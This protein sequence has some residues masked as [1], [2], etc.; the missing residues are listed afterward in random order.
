MFRLNHKLHRAA[1]DQLGWASWWWPGST[2]RA[3]VY[4]ISGTLRV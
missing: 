3:L 1:V 4:T 2:L